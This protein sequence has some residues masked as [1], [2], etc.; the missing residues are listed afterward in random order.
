MPS[1][2]RIFAVAIARI[3]AVSESGVFRQNCLCEGL[4][5]ALHLE[6]ATRAVTSL[7]RSRIHTIFLHGLRATGTAD[8][9]RPEGPDFPLALGLALGWRGGAKRVN[10]VREILVTLGPSA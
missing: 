9:H 4:Q 6:G 7:L 3:L 5:S 8:Q 2:S 10:R 1:R